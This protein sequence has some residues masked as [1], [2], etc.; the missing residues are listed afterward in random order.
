MDEPIRFDAEVRQ[1]KS[2][3]DGSFNLIINIPEYNL[4]QAQ[5][6]MGWLRDQ[7]AVA[8]VR[9]NDGKKNNTNKRFD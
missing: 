2:M 6:L 7:I 5:E 8:I 9:V 3:A 1:I 4:E